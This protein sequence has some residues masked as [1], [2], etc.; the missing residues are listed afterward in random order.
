MSQMRDHTSPEARGRRPLAATI[1]HVPR[2]ISP[3]YCGVTL[4]A[5][6]LSSV[7]V[8]LLPGSASA[9]QNLPAWSIASKPLPTNFAP[10]DANDQYLIVATNSGGAPTDGSEVTVKV[11]LPAGVTATSISG[12][13]TVN[14]TPATCELST[15]TCTLSG[16]T[17]PAEDSVSVNIGVSV[18]SEAVGTA[19]SGVT[20]T[21]GGAAVPASISSPT[22][23][24][25]IPAGFGIS[26]G[27]FVA[28]ANNADGTLATQAG[29]HPF[30]IST[31]FDFNSDASLFPAQR[32][33]DIEVDLPVGLVGNPQ[34]VSTCSLTIFDR[35]GSFG[36]P[37]CPATSQVGTITVENSLFSPMPFATSP[38][39]VYNLE[40]ERGE[41]AAFGTIIAGVGVKLSATVRPDDQGVTVKVRNV[42][43]A[44]LLYGQRLALWGVPADPSHDS[45]RACSYAISTCD[46]SVSSEARPFLRNPTACGGP[47][48]TTLRVDSWQDP[49]HPRSYTST[50]PSITACERAPFSP[51]IAVSPSSTEA[52]VPTG[53]GVELSL[54][55]SENPYGIAT[56]DL[57]TASVALPQGMT[58][59]PASADGLQGCSDA[60]VAIGSDSEV[61][62][63]EASKIG[64]VQIDTPLLEAPLM[65]SIYL[66][67]QAS[68]D[69]ASGQMYRLF[70]VAQNLERGVSIKLA[71]SIVPD[72][73]TG[74][75]SATFDN[76]PQLPFSS[77]HLQFKSGPRAPLSNPTTCGTKTT[78][79]TLTSWSGK[80]VQDQSSFDVVNCTAP[81][82]F[83]PALSAGLLTPAAGAFSPFSLTVSRPDGQADISGLD[84]TLPPGALANLGVVPLCADAEA[85]SGTC[86]SASQ[87]GKVTVAAGSGS[88]PLSVPQAGKAPTAVYLAGPYKG[89]PFSLSIVV[90]A[91]AGPFDLGTVVVRAALFV[92]EHDAHVTVV[93]DP[94]P[95][96]LRGVP[97]RIQRLNVTIDRPGFTFNPTNC[98]AQSVGATISSAEG[99]SAAVSSHF[100][101]ANCATLPFKPKLTASTQGKASKAEGAALS[102]AIAAKGGPQPG[103]GEANIKKVEVQLPKQLPSR[104]TTLQKAC[105]EAQFNTNPAAC[106]HESNVGSAEARTPVLANPLKGPAYLVSHGGAAF[107]DLEIVLQGEGITLILD[108]KTQITKGITYS[109]FQSVPDAPISSFRLSLP[110]GKFSILTANL[111]ESAKYDLCTQSLQMPTRITAQNG[112]VIE[113]KTP[114]AIGGCSSS[115]SIVSHKLN[116]NSVTLSVY[117]PAAGTLKVSGKGLREATKRSKGR[118]TLS[119][120]LSQKRTGKLSTKLELRFVPNKGKSQ[121]KR[122]RAKFKK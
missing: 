103:G 34:A 42:T 32:V 1:L 94:I 21:G 90:P 30:S 58:I 105:S 13:E 101:A 52:S 56:A 91:Q 111:P 22:T 28:Q 79:A 38:T 9:A 74:Q 84:V 43:E 96:I 66:G 115:M 77:L 12:S 48:T 40:A 71:G 69:P 97:L 49:E 107:P 92:D 122:L 120:S 93:S 20:V 17:M 46:Y 54:P 23:F 87:I 31:S 15:L 83:T 33:K 78:T 27:S 88:A 19:E 57:R 114:I 63:P 7:F 95:T 41:A 2:R 11:T 29:A 117:V 99:S 85:A 100:Q 36:Y 81:S 3:A 76:N 72:A 14:F 116:A 80:T 39:P 65:G 50:S 35:L 108:G 18:S 109:R 70:L 44:S 62:C 64:T 25:S 16:V 37:E 121:S 82:L 89:A 98:E 51:S 86:G 73:T 110:S 53:L 106:P 55:Q 5:L 68:D 24:S 113:Q 61:T 102:V 104:L 47:L 26:P 45:T 6:V 59:D 118:E 60:Q 119:L 112:A 75:L 4:L 8:A 67:T 10:G